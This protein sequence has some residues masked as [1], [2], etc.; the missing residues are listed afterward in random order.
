MVVEIRKTTSGDELI[1]LIKCME[2]NKGST[3]A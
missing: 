3:E 2:K 1:K